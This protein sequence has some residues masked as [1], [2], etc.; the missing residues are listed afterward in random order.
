[1]EQHERRQDPEPEQPQPGD[2]DEV[3]VPLASD[4]LTRRLLR[5]Q[6]EAGGG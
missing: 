4:P 1:V 6:V 5:I 3:E 2:L